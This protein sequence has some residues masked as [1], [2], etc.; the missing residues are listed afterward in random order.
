MSEERGSPARGRG[1]TGWWVSDPTCP[2]ALSP[3]G[4]VSCLGAWPRVSVRASRAG[5]PYGGRD[6]ACGRAGAR[7]GG[8]EGLL[9]VTAAGPREGARAE[10]SVPRGR[11]PR[12]RLPPFPTHAGTPR[13]ST[14]E[15]VADAPPGSH[16]APHTQ[17]H[18]RN[19]HPRAV[20]GA[21]K[22]PRSPQRSARSPS[23]RSAPCGPSPPTPAVFWP[24]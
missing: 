8:A 3:R 22:P 12:L 19:S 18:G 21:G 9:S 15:C 5:L 10:G 23:P 1:R 14:R 20:S 11:R 16:H 4:P 7:R 13:G 24:G 17:S 2:P 6:G